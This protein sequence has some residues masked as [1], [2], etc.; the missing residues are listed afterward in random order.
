MKKAVVYGGAGFI[1]SELVRHLCEKRVT[2]CV[3]EK[4]GIKEKKEY[5]RI[6]DLPIQLIECDLTQ[7]DRLPLLIKDRDYDV[8]Y[9]FAWMGL[10]NLSLKDYELQLMN[11][12]WIMDS[13][14]AASELGCSK[15]IGAGSITQKEL[16]I[17]EGRLFQG[18]RHKYY[19]AAEFTCETLGRSVATEYEISFFWPKIINIY[20]P[21]ENSP[22]LINTLI[23]NLRAG[24]EQ[25]LSPGEQLYDFLY[26]TDAAEA[27]YCIGERGTEESEYVI[28]SGDVRPLKDYLLQIRDIVAPEMELQLGALAYEGLFMDAKEFDIS[29]LNKIGFAPK[30]SFEAGIKMLLEWLERQ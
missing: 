9:Q 8:F 29:E 23:R 20:G 17:K 12:K 22:R 3:V 30:V 13:I 7:A 18:D 16:L 11:V 15:F 24:K 19:R 5:E 10:D 4:P 26:I 1:G 2:V 27:Y 28:G 21:G 25:M 6:S 14:V